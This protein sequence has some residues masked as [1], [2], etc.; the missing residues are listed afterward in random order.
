MTGI[1]WLLA[2]ASTAA[3]A[4]TRLPPLRF[5]ERIEYYDVVAKDRATLVEALRVP[6]TEPDRAVNGQTRAAFVIDRR[7]AQ[8]PEGCVINALSIRLEL[9]IILPRWAPDTAL[10][11]RLE[12]H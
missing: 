6:G 11:R 2:L 8:T 9:H 1:G 3:G 5:E 4:E 10:P 12:A 7:F